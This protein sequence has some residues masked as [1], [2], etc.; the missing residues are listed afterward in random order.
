LIWDHHP[1][2]IDRQIDETVAA[3]LLAALTPAGVRPR[4]APP[5]RW[6]PITTLRWGNG[7]CRSSAPL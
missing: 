2:F 5:K 3:A 6:K 7:A 4:C 1:G